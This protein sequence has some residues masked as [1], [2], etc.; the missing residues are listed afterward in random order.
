MAAISGSEFERRPRLLAIEDAA[1]SRPTFTVGELAA[2]DAPA[3]ATGTPAG[4]F[5]EDPA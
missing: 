3:A 5:V 4:T 2:A 1:L